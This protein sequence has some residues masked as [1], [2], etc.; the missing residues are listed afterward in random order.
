MTIK[1]IA[2]NFEQ[3]D[4]LNKVRVH[5]DDQGNPWFIA[6]DVCAALGIVNPR[7][8]VSRLDDDERDDV[9]TSDVI[10]RE[11][12]TNII[13]ES[14]LYSLILTS[15]KGSAKKFKKW[16]TSEV[17]PSIRKTGGY[18]LPEVA[19]AKL[20]E[21]QKYS[22]SL[23]K[24]ISETAV[25]AVQQ[26]LHN[27]LIQIQ[28]VLGQETPSLQTIAQGNVD[29]STAEVLQ[30]FFAHVATLSAL[31]V[32]LNHSHNAS[33]IAINL[34]EYTEHCLAHALPCPAKRTLTAA[35]KQS[36][37]LI[38]GAVTVNS[39]LLGT[40]K[41]CWVFTNGIALDENPPTSQEIPNGNRTRLD[42]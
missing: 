21:L 7:K 34:P 40:S 35:L 18:Q 38:T 4:T 15:R 17:L 10:G 25:P 28:N 19:P 9:T 26:M 41:K 37:R 16:L 3:D 30:Q 5:Q 13:N 14:G 2:F 22:Q 20:V 42:A 31:G 39:R 27:H 8:A 23:L 32:N 36:P 6:N 12:V 11:Q 1:L 29:T 24:R 33:V